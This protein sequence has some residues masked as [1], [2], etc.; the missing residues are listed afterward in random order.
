MLA[1]A[2]LACGEDAVDP[3]Y[4]SDD[5]KLQV[6]FTGAFDRELTDAW[7]N[8]A[9]MGGYPPGPQT[10]VT[11][12]A[13]E[14]GLNVMVRLHDVSEGQLGT[15][16]A[17]IAISQQPSAGAWATPE[18]ACSIEVTQ[19]RRVHDYPDFRHTQYFGSGQ[20]S[21]VATGQQGK[22]GEVTIGDFKLAGAVG[23]NVAGP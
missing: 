21:S 15:F 12:I 11:G 13:I 5:C 7:R 10:V 20:C 22:T 16:D 4:G 8:C 19:W 14:Q 23:W 3:G 9:V 1:V 2:S 17:S 18:R 6:K